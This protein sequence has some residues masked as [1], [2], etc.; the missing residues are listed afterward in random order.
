M[1]IE[2]VLAVGMLL[3]ML[4]LTGCGEHINKQALGPDEYFEYA[5]KK[6]D[7]GDYFKAATEFT[8]I[9]LKFSG[10]PVVDD[11][12]YYL[13][14]SHFK[15]NEYLV[16]ISEYQKLINDYPR[17][18]YQV[19][20]QF[21][22]G[23]CYYKMSLRPSLDQENTTKAIRQF[24]TFIEEN[25]D[26][27]LKADAQNLIQELRERLSKKLMIGA[28]T[29]RKMGIFDAAVVYFDI[30]LSE[31]YDTSFAPAALFWKGECLYKMKKYTESQTALTVYVE[32]YPKGKWR[33][34][35]RERISKISDLLKA[36]EVIQQT[37]LNK[38]NGS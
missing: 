24:Q 37:E 10:N 9:V 26:H 28:T 7:D 15:Q 38:T 23:Y 30:I 22:I 32:K 25:P 13:A 27:E 1:L 16:A 4:A 18:P 3:V 21:K 36:E 20:A 33:D 14:E 5:K 29:Y 35:A 19:L 31:Y 17:S 8:V 2:R 6:F 11:A 12:Q 34:R